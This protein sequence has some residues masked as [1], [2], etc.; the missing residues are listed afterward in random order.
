MASFTQVFHLLQPIQYCLRNQMKYPPVGHL[1]VQKSHLFE[2]KNGKM[3]KS[4]MA[5]T[6]KTIPFVTANIPCVAWRFKQFQRE[7]AKR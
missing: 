4:F 5:K 7:H 1:G 2:D 3:D 6:A